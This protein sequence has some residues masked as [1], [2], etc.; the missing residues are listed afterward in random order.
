MTNIPPHVA[1]QYLRARRKW[2]RAFANLLH[3]IDKRDLLRPRVSWKWA[4]V[5]KRWDL[6]MHTISPY[7][8]EDDYP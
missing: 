1:G 3:G 2:R 4:R 8:I 7:L 5:Y 6:R